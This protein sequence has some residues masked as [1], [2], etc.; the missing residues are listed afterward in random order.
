MANAK[1]V[2]V[3]SDSRA[4][5][6][7][8]AVWDPQTGSCLMV[9]KNAAAIGD[10]CL[11]IINNSYL[12]GADITKS[13]LHIWPLNSQSPVANLRLTTPG[14]ISALSCTS[15]GAY[16]AA[17]VAEKIFIWQTST[18][19]LLRTLGRHYQTVTC[20]KFSDDKS[21]LV[22]GGDDGL[23]YVW[24]LMKI[25]NNHDQSSPVFSHSHHTLPVKDI[26]VGNF[27]A[28]SRLVTVSL[29]RTARIYETHTG[30]QLLVLVFDVPLTSVALDLTETNLFVGCVDGV[31][32][33]INLSSPPR[34]IEHHVPN[35]KNGGVY[36]KSHTNQVTNLSVSVNNQTLLSGSQD[37]TV[38]IWDIPSRQSI[39]T[40]THK[41]PITSAFFAPAYDNFR[42]TNLQPNIVIRPLHRIVNEDDNDDIIEI[43][44][45]KNDNDLLNID[46]YLEDNAGYGGNE[47]SANRLAEANAEIE[48]LKKINNELFKFSVKHLMAD[49]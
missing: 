11:Q 27:G 19:K 45:Q 36:F 6:W 5:T 41:G 18:G 8:S 30:R 23:V 3:T 32:R 38:N 12:I 15:N 28:K 49:K 22:S 7:S 39:R 4:E 42:A 20:L 21:T 33:Q 13:R 26:Y 31:I 37:G 35:E 17:S 43:I 34:G 16:I 29:D 46:D 10:N 48:K 47:D 24:S 40:I 25:I 1:E 2:I 9:Y 14:K 44:S